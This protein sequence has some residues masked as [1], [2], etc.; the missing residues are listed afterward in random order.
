[1]TERVDCPGAA[2]GYTCDRARE[3]F[4]FQLN[5]CRKHQK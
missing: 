4:K 1:M 3:S 2:R 5:F